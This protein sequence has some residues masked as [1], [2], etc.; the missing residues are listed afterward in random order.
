MTTQLWL[1]CGPATPRRRY[2]GRGYGDQILLAF[3]ITT[4]TFLSLTVFTI[5]SKIDF[6]F[7]G[8]ALC[9]GTI[10]LL[11]MGLVLSL[12]FVFGGFSRGW[13]IVF[14]VLGMVCA[15]AR[16]AAQ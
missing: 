3:L 5:F 2:Y 1:P 9:A 10:V 11:V 8:P 15:A 12:A 7:L 6:H 14:A 13:G 16:V 4:A